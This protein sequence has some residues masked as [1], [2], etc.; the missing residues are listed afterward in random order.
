MAHRRDSGTGNTLIGAMR[1]NSRET[2][3]FGQKLTHTD[4]LY[5]TVTVFTTVGFGDVTAKSDGTRLLV[6][7][8]MVADLIILGIGA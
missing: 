1:G 5:F 6:T 7:A 3:N 2:G 8:Q 4:A